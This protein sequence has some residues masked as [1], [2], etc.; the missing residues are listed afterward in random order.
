M[1]NSKIVG[2]GYLE[3]EFLILFVY[4]LSW[5]TRLKLQANSVQ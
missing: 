5:A 4:Q 3:E 2:R 1:E